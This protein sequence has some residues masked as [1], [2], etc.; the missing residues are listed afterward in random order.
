MEVSILHV[1]HYV[2]T[3]VSHTRIPTQQPCERL[4]FC[5]NFRNKKQQ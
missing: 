3:Y 1:H 2:P 5:D 4:H